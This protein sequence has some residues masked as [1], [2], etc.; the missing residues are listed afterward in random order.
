MT[1]ILL[2]PNGI[3]T[4]IILIIAII[5]SYI[6][7]RAYRKYNSLRNFMRI[8]TQ[9]VARKILDENGLNFIVV[10]CS[11]AKGKKAVFNPDKQTL[12]LGLNIYSCDSIA[13]IAITAREVGKIIKYY[14]D[15]R[16]FH[17]IEF[18]SGLST[19]LYSI[20]LLTLYIIFR[21]RIPPNLV[22]MIYKYGFLLLLFAFLFRLIT[23]PF[24]FDEASTAKKEIE[25]RGILLGIELFQ[26]ERM[27]VREV[28]RGLTFF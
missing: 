9:D 7:K 1:K 15:G 18:F 23:I 16:S 19:S 14:N 4:I 5:S 27:L 12:E 17:F 8:K 11:P 22:I 20:W 2:A 21:M 3:M 13:A 26:V 28:L 6:L 10:E 25:D 24:I